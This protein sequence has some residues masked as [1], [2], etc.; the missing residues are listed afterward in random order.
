MPEAR[1]QRERETTTAKS[2]DFRKNHQGTEIPNPLGFQGKME[3]VFMESPKGERGI[4]LEEKQKLEYPK[5]VK[6]EGSLDIVRGVG[7][8]LAIVVL[9]ALLAI[10]IFSFSFE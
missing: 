5:R 3:Q 2:S 7:F 8:G 10:A 9:L 4:C 6:T 1:M